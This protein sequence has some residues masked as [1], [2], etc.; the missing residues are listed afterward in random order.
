MPQI[1]TESSLKDDQNTYRQEI[2]FSV[3]DYASR[4][5]FNNNTRN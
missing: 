4:N 2:D 3:K 1:N 5:T